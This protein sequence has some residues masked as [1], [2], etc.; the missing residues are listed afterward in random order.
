MLRAACLMLGLV[1]IL[2]LASLAIPT[3]ACAQEAAPTAKVYDGLG[4]YGTVRP[5]DGI[6]QITT[7]SGFKVTRYAH[8][9]GK[10]ANDVATVEI[11]HSMGG[12]AALKKAARLKSKPALVITIDPGRAPLWHSCPTGVRCINYYNA[13]HPIGGQYVDG[14]WNIPVFGTMHGAMPSNW[15]IQAHVTMELVMLRASN[16]RRLK[17]PGQR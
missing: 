7:A 12:N 4:M 5:M 6:A 17:G 2:L 14:A 10:Y 15:Y 9:A 11:G 16:P 8:I 13:W 1:V 3:H